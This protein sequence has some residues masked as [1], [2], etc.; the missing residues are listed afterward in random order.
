MNSKMWC[1]S[2]YYPVLRGIKRIMEV[3]LK[4]VQRHGTQGSH[5]LCSNTNE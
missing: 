5:N 1:F 4:R 3:V 2:Q